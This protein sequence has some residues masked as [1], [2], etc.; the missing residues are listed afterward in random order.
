MPPRK[1]RRSAAFAPDDETSNRGLASPSDGVPQAEEKVD[2][3]VWGTFCEE[4]HEGIAAFTP[5]PLPLTKQVLEQLPLTLQRAFTL[6]R[7]LD[8]QAQCEFPHQ[9]AFMLAPTNPKPIMLP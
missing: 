5:L 1:R 2:S 7:E 9:D 4:Y 3:G 6:I 8:D